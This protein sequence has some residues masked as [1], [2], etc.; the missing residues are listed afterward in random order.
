LSERFRAVSAWALG[1]PG[2]EAGPAFWF[3]GAE[4]IGIVGA[5]E[6]SAG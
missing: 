2:D 6:L 3:D 4:V 5:K 1:T